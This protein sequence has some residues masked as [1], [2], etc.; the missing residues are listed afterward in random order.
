V[1]TKLDGRDIERSGD[2]P[3]RVAALK[4]GTTTHVEVWRD[5]KPRDIS[6]ALGELKDA[7]TVAKND[8]SDAGGGRLG[9][10]V[11]PLRPEESKQIGNVGSDGGLLVEQSSGAAAEAGIQQG[12]VILSFNGQPVQSVDQLKGLI[13]KAGGNAA[14]LVQR[15]RARIFV[16][17]E[18]G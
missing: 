11:R 14:L 15:G 1:I 10:A 13:S 8:T 16:P 5:G 2:L 7:V 12:D 6:V 9:V 4:P 3:A 17:V 18:L